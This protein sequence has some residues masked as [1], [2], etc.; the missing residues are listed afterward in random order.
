MYERCELRLVFQQPTW[1]LWTCTVSSEL[2]WTK[3]FICLDM[4]PAPPISA[5]CPPVT[6]IQLI[7]AYHP[8]N[9]FIP[10]CKATEVSGLCPLCLEV[11]G[12]CCVWSVYLVQITVW[13]QGYF[14]FLSFGILVLFSLYIHCA[15]SSC[16][17]CKKMEHYLAIKKWSVITPFLHE[18]C[19]G[20]PLFSFQVY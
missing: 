5:T 10:C 16:F 12:Q 17:Y 18:R 9:A 6:T 13:S 2:V 3:F 14:C 7:C 11:L 20:R 15:V 4:L 19:R 8:V 1:T